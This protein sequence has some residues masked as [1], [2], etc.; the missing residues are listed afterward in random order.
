MWAG[1][2]VLRHFGTRLFCRHSRHFTTEFRQ[3]Y[4]VIIVG[5]GIMGLSC[6]YFLARR[7]NPSSI[8][9]IERDLKVDNNICS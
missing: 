8:C 3:N 9:I 1:M 7:I 6:A 4:E 2:A 5:G